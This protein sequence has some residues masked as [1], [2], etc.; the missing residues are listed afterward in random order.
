MKTLYCHSGIGDILM[1][2]MVCTTLKITPEII[3]F[4]KLLMKEYSLNYENRVLFVTFFINLIFDDCKIIFSEDPIFF[5]PINYFTKFMNNNFRKINKYYMCENIIDKI[6]KKGK[7][8][9]LFSEYVVIHMKIRMDYGYEKFKTNAYE[10]ILSFLNSKIVGK[11]IVLLGEKTI[12]LNLESK[13]HKFVSL[14]HDLVSCKSNNNVT[15]L[16][17]D[18]IND[19]INLNFDNFIDDINIIHNAKLNIIIGIG[20][21]LTISAAFSN[22]FI[23]YVE[24]DTLDA[25]PAIFPIMEQKT[26]MYHEV[27]NFIAECNTLIN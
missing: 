9:V 27:N 17:T 14:Y 23:S 20:G 5:S 8:N 10:Q 7:K 13:I 15:D 21:P 24:K 6:I 22:N 26:K 3:I 25:Y 19:H 12:T 11:N 1:L 4:P 18:T 16:T 2:K